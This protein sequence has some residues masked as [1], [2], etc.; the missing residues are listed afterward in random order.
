MELS[1]QIAFQIAEET[2]AKRIADDTLKALIATTNKVFSTKSQRKAVVNNLKKLAELDLLSTQ[3]A[4][5]TIS[6]E[7]ANEAAEVTYS[8]TKVFKKDIM[9]QQSIA[10]TIPDMIGAA[11]QND[12]NL[13]INETSRLLAEGHDNPAVMNALIGTE[14]A[15]FRDGTLGQVATRQETLTRTATKI[16]EQVG[17]EKARQKDPDIIG[18][19][20][21]SVL[22][23]NTTLICFDLAGNEYYY[24]RSGEKP[25]PPQHYNC[26]STTGYISKTEGFEQQ[27]QS[28]DEW[29]KANPEDAEAAMG[30][31]RYK[32]YTDGRLKIQRFTDLK[33][34]PL[35]LDQLKARNKRAFEKA[36]L[37]D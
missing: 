33:A 22:D 17:M 32:L 18:Y 2:E 31:E 20:W 24:D 34:Q 9:S 29:A 30:K 27:P 37:D 13:I 36:G 23:S 7:F 26:R 15:D 28:F 12:L 1:M 25:L 21:I 8:G 6:L 10:G 14:S 11:H 3:S 16:S 4:I 5:E 35:T 19:F